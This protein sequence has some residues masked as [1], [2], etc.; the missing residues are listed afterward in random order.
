MFRR[1]LAYS[2]LWLQPELTSGAGAYCESAAP[3]APPAAAGSGPATEP[4]SPEWEG[5]GPHFLMTGMVL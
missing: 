5:G 1:A 4:P 2:L 3:S